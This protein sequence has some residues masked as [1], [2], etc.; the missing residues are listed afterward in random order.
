MCQASWNSS[1]NGPRVRRLKS[2]YSSRRILSLI[3]SFGWEGI[4]HLYAY[5]MPILRHHR[6]C[7]LLPRSKIKNEHTSVHDYLSQ[8][9]LC[10][11]D[12][13]LAKY[14]TDTTKNPFVQLTDKKLKCPK[15]QTKKR[16]SINKST[17][18]KKVTDVWSAAHPRCRKQKR[19]RR[20]CSYTPQIGLKK[21][22]KKHT[23]CVITHMVNEKYPTSW[24]WSDARG[25]VSRLFNPFVR[26]VVIGCLW[27]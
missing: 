23:Q 17:I 22:K 3:L 1:L 16:G 8:S 20:K 19:S 9:T 11:I 27:W 13:H 25:T 6:R 4:K 2:V 26:A 18:D 5:K 15:L 14:W 12:V 7:V 21:F 10:R 24:A